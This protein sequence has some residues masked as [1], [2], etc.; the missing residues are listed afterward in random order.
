VLKRVSSAH[1]PAIPDYEHLSKDFL[2]REIRAWSFQ[3]RST[4]VRFAPGPQGQRIQVPEMRRTSRIPC[5]SGGDAR[6]PDLQQAGAGR[7]EC[8]SELR[9]S[10]RLGAGITLRI[11]GFRASPSCEARAFA[12]RPMPEIIRHSR[13]CSQQTGPGEWPRCRQRDRNGERHR[14]HQRHRGGRAQARSRQSL[15]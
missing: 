11:A 6:V 3:R 12:Q 2:H 5:C 9:R 1:P 4:S 8:M 14:D 13:P 15:S 7:I 10:F